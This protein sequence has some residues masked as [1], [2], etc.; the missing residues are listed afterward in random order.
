MIDKYYIG[1]SAPEETTVG[2]VNPDT[3]ELKFWIGGVWKPIANKTSE[4]IDLRLDFI[5]EPDTDNYSLNITQT[6]GGEPQEG[7]IV[8]LTATDSG[9]FAEL[10]N[11]LVC[12]VPHFMII[13]QLSSNLT[14]DVVGFPILSSVYLSG[15]NTGGGALSGYAQ[16]DEGEA[17]QFDY[18]G[19]N[20]TTKQWETFAF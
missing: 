16:V 14:N 8:R 19:Y 3:M 13:L 12:D 2:W 10:N 11:S 15:S 5:F 9:T 1:T 4:V 18:L 6:S 7:S 20:P 17:V